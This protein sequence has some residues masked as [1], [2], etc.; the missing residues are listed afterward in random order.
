MSKILLVY[1]DFAELNATELSLKKSGF[2]VIGLTN[3]YTVKDQIVT[4][5]PDILVG[6]GNSQ[7]VGS[8][9]V[10]KKIKD[11][12]R[13]TGKS[14]LIFPKGYEL[15][16]DELIRMRMDMLLE[17]PISVIRLIQIICKLLKLDEKS[18][19]EKLA[20]SFAKD[21]HDD[22]AFSSYDSDTVKVIQ[23]IQGE[24]EKF[25]SEKSQSVAIPEEEP[26][27][28]AKKS[29]FEDESEAP[30]VE[31]K[32]DDPFAALINE[33]KGESN[34]EPNEVPRSEVPKKAEAK[35]DVSEAAVILPDDEVL[36]F[37]VVGQQIKDEIAQTASELSD[38]VKKYTQMTA[39]LHLYPEST[40]KKVKAKK[41]LNDL[42][43][44]WSVDEL[45]EQ[46]KARREFVTALM[47]S[48]KV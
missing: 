9:S 26:P 48:D 13:W 32:S 29:F 1:D 2:D 3:E 30:A 44:G 14:V 42:K 41:Q 27:R 22:L 8:L 36:D 31:A 43:K 17:S 5:N 46:D 16:A 15:A 11:M 45:E 25:G 38:K 47:K 24:L 19:I 37:N 39:E 4:F 40:I 21:R 7:R 20:K 6:F 10:G 35:P 12:N 33:L 23:H 34:T 28:V 18:V